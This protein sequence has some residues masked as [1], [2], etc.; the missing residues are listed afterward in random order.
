[1]AL[2]L[3]MSKVYDWMEWRCLK[4]I[5][6]KM[7]FDE[8]WVNIMMR[9]ISIVKYFVKIHG[10]PQGYITPSRGLRQRDP[11]SPY[12]FFIFAEGLSALLKQ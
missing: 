11:L 10:K 1:M 9:C 12:L 4:S 6:K 3:D 5:M 7:G 2:K 8:K